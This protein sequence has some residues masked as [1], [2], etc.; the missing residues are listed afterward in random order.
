MGCDVSAFNALLAREKTRA[1]DA[2]AVA[3]GLAATLARA[4]ARSPTGDP[5]APRPPTSREWYGDEARREL[6][7]YRAAIEPGSAWSGLASLVLTRAA[8][9]ARLVRH[10]AL[11]G[12]RTPVR[13]PYWCHKHR[14]TCVPT[15]GALRFLR[16]YS[17]RRRRRASRR[18]PRCA[19]RAPARSSGTSTRASSRLERPADALVTSP[20]YVGVIDYHDQHAYAYA[21][22]GLRARPQRGDRQPQPRR[23]AR[24]PCAPT[25]TTWWRRSRRLRACLRPGAPL[26][27]VV[28]DRLGLYGEI[29][30]RAGLRLE[31]RTLRHVN[32]RT[33]RRAG[34]Y[35]E[36]ILVARRGRSGVEALAAHVLREAARPEAELLLDRVG[37]SSCCRSRRARA[38]RA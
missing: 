26:A 10:D 12:A 4:E 36:E 27:I 14:R 30:E 1:H 3:A 15:A 8:R 32:R 33:S 6:L 16:R 9:S 13:E 34:E 2:A 24:A 25:P 11:D 29:L 38:R 20:P 21:L 18:S 19:R 5:A 23:R 22:L 37:R 35:F 31:S 28:N 7:A 17:A